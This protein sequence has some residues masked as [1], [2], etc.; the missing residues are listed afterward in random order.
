MKLSQIPAR[1]ASHIFKDS[2]SRKVLFAAGEKMLTLRKIPYGGN[3]LRNKAIDLAGF[4]RYGR[5][6]RDRPR[7][8]SCRSG[9]LWLSFLL[10]SEPNATACG[11]RGRSPIF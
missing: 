8:P 5:I 10:L 3:A 4:I 9:S 6:A 2:F 1:A 7:A 11:Q